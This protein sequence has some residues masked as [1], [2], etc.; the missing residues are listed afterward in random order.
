MSKVA[1]RAVSLFMEEGYCC[2]E[3]GWLAFAESD[4]ISDE[5]KAFGNKLTFAFCGG[6]GGRELCGAVA[7]GVLVLGRWFGRVPGEPRNQDLPKYTKALLDAFKAEFGH[8]TCLELKLDGDPAV[9]RKHCSEYVRF[10]AAKVE[11]LLDNGL[12]G[13]E[14]DCG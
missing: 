8:M 13:E 14:A 7:G 3:A 9:S 11:E 2:A 5:E 12:P 10:V 6:T 4:G 1:D